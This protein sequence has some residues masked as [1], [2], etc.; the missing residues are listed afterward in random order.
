MIC[1]FGPDGSGKTTLAHKLVERLLQEGI[2]VR[3]AWLRGSHTF[4]SV[5]AKILK[6]FAVFQGEDNPYY[7]LSIP[8]RMILLW[9]LIEI[10]SILPVWFARYLI[11]RFLGYTVIGERSLLDFI[12]WVSITTRDYRFPASIGG[13]IFLT[14]SLKS[15]LNV[16]VTANIKTLI[17]RRKHEHTFKFLALQLAFYNILAKIIK[18]PV[19]DTTNTSA[20]EHLKG[21]GKSFNF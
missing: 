14:I 11:P 8:K 16:Y 17:E 19:I 12:V 21:I 2:Q 13:K 10:L 15:C 5:L 1:F 9:E 3:L 20:E 7:G 18:A 6:R 4:A